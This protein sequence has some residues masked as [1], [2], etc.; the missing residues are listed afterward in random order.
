MIDFPK[1]FRIGPRIKSGRNKIVSVQQLLP[2]RQNIKQATQVYHSSFCGRYYTI[3]IGIILSKHEID[4]P[5]L[6]FKRGLKFLSRTRLFRRIL[7][8]TSLRLHSETKRQK[9]SCSWNSV[10]PPFTPDHSNAS[11]TYRLAPTRYQFHD[12][13]FRVGMNS[14]ILEYVC[15]MTST[16][17]VLT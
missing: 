12:R 11:I 13:G 15:A 6:V 14:V 2:W 7:R 1:H 3:I 16:I 8:D 4:K 5:I 17:F 9:V 10:T